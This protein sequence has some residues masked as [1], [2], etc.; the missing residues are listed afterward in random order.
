MLRKNEDVGQ[1]ISPFFVCPRL[2]HLLALSLFLFL[3]MHWFTKL[4][5][6]QS[7]LFSRRSNADSTYSIS[8]PTLT[9]CPMQANGRLSAWCVPALRVCVYCGVLQVNTDW[10]DLEFSSQIWP[11]QPVFVF[12]LAQSLEIYA[13]VYSKVV[14]G[15]LHCNWP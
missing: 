11:I 14:I 1:F 12:C 6:N 5:A 2:C 9:D 15:E 13:V 10:V 8:Q 7:D 4:T 3:F